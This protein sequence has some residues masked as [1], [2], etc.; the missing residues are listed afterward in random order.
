[1]HNATKPTLLFFRFSPE[2]LPAYIRL[3]LQQH[4]KCLSQFFEVTVIDRP[5]DYRQLCDK[6]QPDLALFESGVYVGK[7]EIANISAYPEIPKLGFCHCDSYCETREVFVSDMARWGVETFF[8]TSVSLASY[9]PSLADNLFVWPNFVD[10]AIYHD[11]G[12]PKLI[13]ALFTGSQATHYPWR[14][15][16]N[17]IISQVYPSLQCP[18]FGWYDERATSRMIFGEPYARMINAAWIAPTCGT[19]AN[20]LVRKHFEIPACKA[21]LVTQR[22]SA[23]EAAGFSDLVNC[24]FADDADV[25]EKLEWLFQHRD[26]LQKITR[27]GYDLVQ[28]QHG[29]RQRDQVFQWFTLYKQLKPHQRVVQVGP[30][31]P[32]TIVDRNSGIR[33]GHL[34]SGGLDRILLAQGDEN[35]W[36]GRYD[37]AESLYRR[38]LNYHNMPEPKLRLALCCLY[39]GYADLAI[40]WISEVTQRVLETYGAAEP[41]AVEWA[42]FIVALLCRGKLREAVVR[43]DQF[44]KLCHPELER[45]RAVIRVLTGQ[46]HQRV[47][48]KCRLDYRWSIHQLPE[49]R[50]EAWLAEI[51][52]ML[53]A[54]RQDHIVRR[55]TRSAAILKSP[56]AVEGPDESSPAGAMSWRRLISRSGE[57]IRRTQLT[58]RRDL[59]RVKVDGYRAR[60]RSW[61]SKG[62]QTPLLRPIWKLARKLKVMA[63]YFLPYVWS[64]MRYD[65]A[66]VAVRRLLGE[67]DIKSGLLIG[68]AAGEGNTEAFLRGISEN[69][70]KPLA[71]CMNFATP[72]FIRLKRRLAKNSLVKCRY[73]SGECA[74]HKDPTDSF[75]AVVIDGSEIACTIGSNETH[76][77]HLIVLDDINKIQT[78]KLCHTL[79]ADCNYTL[80]A[81]N[82]SHRGGYAIF[83]R[84]INR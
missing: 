50:I 67:A 56:T 42:Y 31:M 26:E 38:C 20:E 80:L 43:V 51:C 34:S 68:A 21:C 77:A 45:V 82:P 78:Y 24:V 11:Y 52:K 18:H 58:T 37:E 27:A 8:T 15:R 30:F 65:E 36:S 81:H 23:L 3:H 7:R 22:T 47:P 83:R 10:P 71:V 76:S 44:E 1:M 35:L 19:I 69:P 5:S 75:D 60:V 49:R 62:F 53:K 4:V 28:S 46:V 9:T 54:C 55:L 6:H 13:P 70:N 61:L 41:D 48:S 73:I 33:N 2:S 32:L 63:G 40:Q 59:Y 39:K 17:K 72:R 84:V 64:P 79:L 25:I 74:W 57:A 16:I 12:L 14:N 29:I 66:L